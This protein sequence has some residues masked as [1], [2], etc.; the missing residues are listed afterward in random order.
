[1]PK[2]QG[3]G[4]GARNQ[5]TRR[6]KCNHADLW[7]TTDVVESRDRGEYY[8]R[9]RKCKTCGHIF[10][11]EERLRGA[12]PTAP[13]QDTVEPKPPLKKTVKKVKKKNM[14]K[15]YRELSDEQLEQAIFDGDVRFDEDEL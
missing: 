15:D 9:R 12:V 2:A 7:K 1:M 8:F 13:P 14:F 3:V 6:K 10:R 4:Q 11:T 5:T